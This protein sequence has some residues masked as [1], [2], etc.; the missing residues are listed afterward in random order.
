MGVEKMLPVVVV[1]GGGGGG[2]GIGFVV[3]FIDYG[4]GLLIKM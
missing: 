3:G 4:F 1:G 2:G